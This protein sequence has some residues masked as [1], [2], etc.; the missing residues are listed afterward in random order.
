MKTNFAKYLMLAIAKVS[1]CLAIAGFLLF[2]HISRLNDLTRLQLQI[3]K[4][5]KEV[6]ALKEEIRHLQYRI[7]QFH[8]P[9]HLMEL[10][11]QKEYS[12]LQFPQQTDVTT[13][14]SD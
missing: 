4:K 6:F 8:D 13:I 10:L 7:G 11:H 9:K 12:H 5:E 2:L 14:G 3:P 1:F